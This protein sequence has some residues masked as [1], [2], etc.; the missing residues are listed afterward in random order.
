M[1][2]LCLLL[3]LLCQPGHALEPTTDPHLA[4]VRIKSHGCSG[5]VIA[6]TDGKSWIL[7]CCHMF[8]DEKGR[9]DK[10]LT[11]KKFSIDGPL[12]PYAPKTLAEVKLLALDTDQDL[13][14]LEIANGPFHWLAVAP[15]GHQPSRNV[16]SSGYASMAWP[17]VTRDATILQTSGDW[18]WTREKPYHGQSGG[19]LLDLGPAG[20]T[21]RLIG[22]TYG[23]EAH[24]RMRGVYASH[25]SVLRF[26]AAYQAQ[27]GQTPTAPPP[28]V[29]HQ[30]F[31]RPLLPTPKQC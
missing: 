10:S 19:A 22:V 8:L 3:L 6:A 30:P 27:F 13:S 5:T 17:I 21:P 16:R 15:K 1:K 23:Y 4:M 9:I 24:G 2:K 25:E 12:Q 28:P 7:S 14:L 31:A 26:L 29:R 18:T 20:V 11:G